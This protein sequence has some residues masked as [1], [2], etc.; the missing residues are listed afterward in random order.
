MKSKSAPHRSTS[1][2]CAAIARRQSPLAC[3]RPR[4]PP[5]RASAL[6]VARIVASGAPAYGINTG[7]GR[8]SQTRIRGQTISRRCRR[9]IVLSHAAGTGA[10]ARRRDRTPGA[11]AEDRQPR[12]RRLGRAAGAGRAACRAVQARHLSVH[13]RQRL[14]RRLGRS[15]ARSRTSRSRCSGIGDVRVDGR[16][17]AAKSAGRCRSRPAQARAEGGP[18]APQRHAGFDR[19]RA[20]GTLRGGGCLRRGGRRRAAFRSMP[21]PAA[22]R[23]STARIHALRGHTGQR[24]VAAPLSRSCSPTARS[25]A[26]ISRTTRGCR[27]RTACAASRR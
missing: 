24:D 2:A 7:F 23:R 3:P 12:S 5:S 11:R 15:G 20:D 26:R 8:L 10:A 18:G 22:T 9:N 6:T 1:R 4:T 27:I 17:L 19:A 25:A 13:P 16:T 21:P 14:G